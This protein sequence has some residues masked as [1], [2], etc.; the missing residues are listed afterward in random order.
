MRKLD[1]GKQIWILW[2]GEHFP[3][4]FGAYSSQVG[5]RCRPRQRHGHTEC[6][7]YKDIHILF[8][9]L[10]SFLDP[11]IETKLHDVG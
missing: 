3:E 2:V 1:K 4:F 6:S 7:I 10:S 8:F 11:A 5:L 9:F